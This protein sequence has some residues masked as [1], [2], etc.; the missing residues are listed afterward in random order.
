MRRRTFDALA[1]VA[2]LILAAVLLVAGV[3]LTWGH[4]FVNNEVASQ[5]SAQ[6]IE[7]PTTTSPGFKALPKADQAAMGSYAGQLMTNGAQA[8]TYADHFIAVHLKEIGGGGT[9]S[10]LSAEAMA[11]PPT[12]KQYAALEAQVQTVFR[13]DTLRSMLLNA[14]GFWKMGQIAFIA[15]IV[16][17]AAAGLLLILSCLGFVHLRRTA[18]EAE[19]MPTI[20]RR[21]H[22]DAS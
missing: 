21:V 16:S 3:L 17:Y 15:A 2:G 18:P 10:Q 4:S 13:G 22:V 19:I 12:S 7:F 8:E 11:L 5:L 14:Y 9:Y 20:A 6:K 1:T